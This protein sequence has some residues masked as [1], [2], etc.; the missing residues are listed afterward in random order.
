MT[1]VETLKK[2]IEDG[3]IAE[4]QLPIGCLKNEARAKKALKELQKEEA[5]DKAAYNL[6]IDLLSRKENILKM[7]ADATE[8]S[9]GDFLDALS[10]EAQSIDKMPEAWRV[11]LD[12]IA[13]QL[14][15]ELLKTAYP[16]AVFVNDAKIKSVIT[17][18]L[19]YAPMV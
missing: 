14:T 19:G 15:D 5:E 18:Q 2:M 6:V 7:F 9:V 3:T 10:G 4:E 8:G 17:E 13:G 11:E 12:S 1:A 16:Y